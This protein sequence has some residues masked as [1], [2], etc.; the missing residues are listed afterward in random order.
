V[1]RRIASQKSADGATES[2]L[3]S[4]DF[5]GWPPYQDKRNLLPP[6]DWTPERPQIT[7][8]RAPEWGARSWL[9]TTIPVENLTREIKKSNQFTVHIVCAPAATED[10]NGRILSFSQS[11][12]NVDFLLRQQGQFL[13]LRLRNPLSER[14]SLLAWYVPGAFQSGKMRDI[15]ASYDGSDA[16]LYLDG[17][18]VPHPFRLG[19]GASLTHKFFFIDI[20][21]LEGYIIAYETLVFLPAGFLIGF[22]LWKCP[23]Q[24]L[25]GLWMLA[26]GWAL[27]AVLLEIF[28]AGI[29]G[30]RI[31]VGNIGFS[32]VFGVAG[33]LLINADQRFKH[34]PGV[35]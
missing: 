15:V 22:S 23:G 12:A 20:G 24:K 34:S 1:I 18:P 17:N 19:P 6:L 33:M 13:V 29:S 11:A 35:S 5:T 16:F 30:R 10:V 14:R 9:S 4:Y 3:G 25:I 28:L 21:S 32:L 2:S 27:P 7:T 31:W 26:L 8:G